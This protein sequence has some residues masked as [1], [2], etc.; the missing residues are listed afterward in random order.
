MAKHRSHGRGIQVGTGKSVRVDVPLPLL[1]VVLDTRKAFPELCIRTGREVLLAMMEP[2]REALCGPKGLHQGVRRVWRAGSTSS[3]VTLGG[4]QV[5]L[6]RLRVRSAEGEAALASFQWA[7]STG[8]MDA[9]T[10]ETITAGVSTRGFQMHDGT[11]AA[12]IPELRMIGPVDHV[13]HDG[14][15]TEIERHAV[16]N[17][18]VRVNREAL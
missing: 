2:D 6:P 11:L 9:H 15:R 7:A 12:T 17:A 4:R 18:E 5:E 1:G 3:R 10:L 13:E 8:A 16:A 14:P